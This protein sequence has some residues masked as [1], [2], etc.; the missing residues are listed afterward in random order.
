MVTLLQETSV[1]TNDEK[2][3]AMLKKHPQ[4]SA[5]DDR[6]INNLIPAIQTVTISE[7]TVYSTGINH[8]REVLPR[9]QM[10]I[11]QSFYRAP[12]TIL[13]ARLYQL[14]SCNS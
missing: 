13:T 9:D 12:Y 8:Q 1:A 14:Q 7:D 2:R 5:Q 6:D 3:N 10:V 4:R 11:E